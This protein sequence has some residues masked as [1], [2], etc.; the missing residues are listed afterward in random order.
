LSF[1]R[2]LA[3]DCQLASFYLPVE[4]LDEV[5]ALNCTSIRQKCIFIEDNDFH[6]S[7]SGFFV[8][9]IRDYRVNSANYLYF[10]CIVYNVRITGDDTLPVISS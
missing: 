7:V 1:F 6:E 4:E 9:G 2:K 8:P 5:V 3:N 10:L